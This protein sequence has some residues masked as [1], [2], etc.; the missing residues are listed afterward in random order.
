MKTTE[1]VLSLSIA[2]LQ[3]AGLFDG[4]D[5]EGTI[6]TGDER[7]LFIY[8]AQGAGLLWIGGHPYHLALVPSNLG[9]GHLRYFTC[10]FTHRRTR[11]LYR[12]YPHY[13]FGH[14]TAFRP[15]IGY[16]TQLT[17]RQYHLRR[18]FELEEEADQLR[19]QIT[20]WEHRGE[21]T[22]RVRRLEAMDERAAR[23]RLHAILTNRMFRSVMAFRAATTPKG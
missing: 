5:S 2:H 22:R 13:P 7:L 23:Y 14:R 10:P 4:R 16:A 6:G 9:R 18:S 17:G 11:T 3:A 19:E 1:Q 8:R 12:P 15:A 20:R 21:P